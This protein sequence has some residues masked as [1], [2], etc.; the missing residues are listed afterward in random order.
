IEPAPD[1]FTQALA[2]ALGVETSR[3]IEEALTA[4][5]RSV[6][7]ID[8][9]ERLT[10]LEGWLREVFFPQL[11]EGVMIVMAGRNPLVAEWRL[12]PGWRPLLRQLSLRNLSVEEGQQYL[13]QRGVP[14]AEQPTVLSFTHGHPLA[15]SLVADVFDQRPNIHFQ[16]TDMP[17]VL[18]VL[19]EQFA[20]KV[21]SPAHRAALEACALVRVMTEGLLA[22]IL[23]ILDA[24]ELFEWL[25]DLS[26]IESSAEG[27]FPHDLARDTL[28]AELR[29]RNPD[30]YA[31]LH[32]RARAYYSNRLLQIGPL[33]QQQ[34]LY[35]FIFLHRD[36]S[37]VRP[38]FEWQAS[39]ALPTRLLDR[40]GPV[41]SAM[42]ETHEGPL[43]AQRLRY[44]VDRH[45]EFFLVFRDSEQIPVGFILML[46]LDQVEDED[47]RADPPVGAILRY[48]QHHAPLRAGETATFFRFWMANDT[49]QAVSSV[50]SQIFV[51]MVRHYLVTPGL[52]YTF[53]PCA[54]PDF[55]AP[56]FGYADLARL[57]NLDFSVD[58]RRHG[59]YGHDWR[60][61]PPMAWLALMGE[62]EL[63]TVPIMP[64]QP[65]E[66]VIVLGMSEF[67][68]AVQ[69]ALKNA[70]RP[71]AL[72]NSPLLRSRLVVERVGLQADEVSRTNE[73]LSLLHMAADSLQASPRDIKLYRV[74]HHTY[75]Q[76]AV[77]QEMAAEL[78]DLPFSTYRRHLK[79]AV[80]R[81]T[82]I[83]WQ[84]EIEGAESG[85]LR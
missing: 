52:A 57:P 46:A 24:H 8:T 54:D 7:L 34:V 50:Q 81:T 48:L 41:L 5:T 60:A 9:F 38:F 23:S 68:D 82:E 30:W 59:V 47:V 13:T 36:N 25:R 32:S 43:S 31:E 3:G 28:L 69:D 58:G 42:V 49:Y 14:P 71:P 63:G 51:N 11:P 77:T 45:P 1:A 79:K 73:L 44:W 72:H 20:Q 19:L 10:P 62:R 22:S 64:P 17:D 26:F 70:T 78:L 33:E 40:D 75:F 29:W 37:M 18:K 74:L 61:V 16:P 12:D 6:I 65:A 80:E 4:S 76:P 85:V 84:Q 55:W 2:L 35:D 56:M 67:G 83:L 15:L 66:Q 27:I 21:P 39:S 53:I